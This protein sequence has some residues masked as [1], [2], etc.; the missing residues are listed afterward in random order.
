MFGRA[1]A[2]ASHHFDR[3]LPSTSPLTPN[4]PPQPRL[5]A[6]NIALFQP[7][8]VLGDIM[9]SAVSL[10]H[11]PHDTDLAHDKLLTD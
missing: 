6:P 4:H 5:Y 2:V 9:D 8:Y 3:V 1:L 10:R 7:P 11:V